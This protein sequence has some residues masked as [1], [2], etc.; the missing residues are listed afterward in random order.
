MQI[1]VLSAANARENFVCDHVEISSYFRTQALADHDAYNVR[2]RVAV[3]EQGGAP[4]GFY[5]LV[6]GVLQPKEVKIFNRKF[7]TKRTVPSVYLAAVAVQSDQC[8]QGIGAL[9]ML[10]A[11]EK[12]AKIAELAGTACMT[13]DAIDEDKARWYEKLRFERFGVHEDGRI[14][15]F[16]PLRTIQ[17]ALAV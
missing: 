2:V 14:K 17:E 15:M 12:V 9:L 8:R 4:A 16:V 1:E 13:L 11:F 3:H 6:V 7:G 10:D 5:S